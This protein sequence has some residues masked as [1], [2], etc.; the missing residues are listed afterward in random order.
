MS[1]ME[2]LGKEFPFLSMEKEKT[3][4]LSNAR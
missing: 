1:Q 2:Q 3:A 4:I